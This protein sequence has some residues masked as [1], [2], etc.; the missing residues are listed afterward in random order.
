MD[1]AFG[2]PEEL[3]NAFKT[4]ILAVASG[5]LATHRMVNNFCLKGHWMH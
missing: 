5:C 3:W 2:N 1:G 4:T